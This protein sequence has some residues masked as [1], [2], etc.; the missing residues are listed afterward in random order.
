MW[1]SGAGLLLA[2]PFMLLATAAR[3]PLAIFGFIFL[4]QFFVFLNQGPINSALVNAV[5]PGFRAFAMGLNVL[6]IHLLGDAASPTVIGWIGDHSSLQTAIRVNALPVLLG[7]VV[8]VVGVQ[9]LV[10]GNAAD[11]RRG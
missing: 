1:V 10:K 2:T 3:A 7:G 8:L 4:T 6:I 11:A 9:T 5:S